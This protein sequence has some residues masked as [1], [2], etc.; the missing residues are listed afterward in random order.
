MKKSIVLSTLLILLLTACIS[1]DPKEVHL[2]TDECVYCKMVVS[3]MQ[4]AS[5]MVSD[6][7]KSYTFDSIECMAA[8][9]YQNPDHAGKSKMYVS[10]YTR[11]KQW[12]LIDNANIYHAETIQSPMGLSLFAMPGHVPLP[13]DIGD[14]ELM[15]WNVT[16]NYVV[17]KWDLQR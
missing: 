9:H 10:D 14:A 11:Q 8:Y 12:I 17:D 13:S 7:G 5:Q 15:N 16:V 1:Q 2:H 3:D 4:F 6:K